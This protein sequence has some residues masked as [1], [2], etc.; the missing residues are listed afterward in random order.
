M[1]CSSVTSLNVES[2]PSVLGWCCP[3]CRWLE[4]RGDPT[5]PDPDTT[6]SCPVRRWSSEPRA[7]GEGGQAGPDTRSP[8][9]P[10][11]SG[12]TPLQVP[13]S[14]GATRWGQPP[15]RA[16]L[17]GVA[18]RS[19]LSEAARTAAGATPEAAEPRRAFPRRGAP[20]REPRAGRLLPAPR[21]CGA[22]PRRRCRPASA[23]RPGR[24]RHA[25]LGAPQPAAAA[26]NAAAR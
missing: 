23:Q 16:R 22:V 19:S 18:G 4:G 2:C 21:R 3:G 10:R 14:A 13:W 7:A 25:A 15:G 5:R 17:G 8:G 20:G 1:G 11:V 6:L 24:S 26:G 9:L 12:E